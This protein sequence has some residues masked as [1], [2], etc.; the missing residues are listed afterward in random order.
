MSPGPRRMQRES[1]GLTLQLAA[2]VVPGVVPALSLQGPLLSR[3]C[4]RHCPR[5]WLLLR[6]GSLPTCTHGK[7]SGGW[8]KT[9][10]NVE[11]G[12]EEADVS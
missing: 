4:L 9:Q 1:E 7:N 3:L 11:K 5:A 8:Q 10:K 2:R 12:Q 6:E